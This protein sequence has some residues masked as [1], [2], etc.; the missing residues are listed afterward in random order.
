MKIN[1]KQNI[2][3][4]KKYWQIVYAGLLIVLIPLA[5]IANT[6]WITNSFRSNINIQLQRQALSLAEVFN[7][8]LQD[9]LDDI[10]KL[11]I[12]LTRVAALNPD[13]KVA[14]ILVP[15]GENFKVVAS[16]NP[17][18]VGTIT[19]LLINV[20]AWHQ[21]QA[22]ANLT[23][24]AILTQ[25]DPLA[26]RTFENLQER[27]WSV[28]IPLL[29][30]QGQKKVLLNLNM[31][32]N[33]VDGLVRQTLIRSYLI[34][35]LAVVIVMLLLAANT[36]LF[37]YAVLA[38]KLKEVEQLKDEFIAMASHELRTPITSLRG[39]LS[40]MNDGDLG[41]ISDMAQDK[42]KMMLGSADR[43]SDLVEDLLNVSRIEQGR[44][45]INYEIA[46]LEP[47]IA[48]VM[49]ELQV[50]ADDKN[51]QFT[52]EKPSEPLPKILVDSNRLK[53]ILVNIIGNSIKY[54]PKGSVTITSIYLPD[55]KLVEIKCADTGLGM[56]QK[57]RERLFTKFYRVKTKD[58][59]HIKGTG[60]GLWITK[61]LIE[62]M[63]GEI[64]VDSIKDVGTQ[65]AINFPVKTDK[66][67]ALALSKQVDDVKEEAET[68]KKKSDKTAKEESVAEE[69][70]GSETA[71]EQ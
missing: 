38:K 47:I 68:E 36:R 11:Q 50:Q 3:A 17:N 7:G 14:D 5:I 12:S 67:M 58:T 61:Q 48:G 18:K 33:I 39:Y 62:L 1:I 66:A 71:E 25:D 23:N 20:I 15:E 26:T 55:E 19:P 56:T 13:I 45:T 40:M 64:L 2:L 49:A 6:V 24:A 57:Q 27:F 46:E 34:L 51:L 69:E 70:S 43:L 21:E 16:L 37:Q 52:Y 54:T 22:I 65:M 44:L 10:E 8:A 4:L 31:S 42:V 9:D 63:G 41:D 59:E 30:S 32:L 35:S 28:T 53:Q 60:L 29:D